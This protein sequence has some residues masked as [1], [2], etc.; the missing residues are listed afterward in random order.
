MIWGTDVLVSRRRLHDWSQPAADSCWLA[1]GRSCRQAP[2]ERANRR[3][4]PAQCLKSRQTNRRSARPPPGRHESC[5][6][7]AWR[8]GGSV[9]LKQRRDGRFRHIA[10][11]L[12]RRANRLHLTTR[13]TSDEL[14]PKPARAA[15]SPTRDRR[16]GRANGD[17]PSTRIP[18]R[19]G[20]ARRQRDCHSEP[21]DLR[22]CP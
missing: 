2:S 4:C 8:Q 13:I 14:A 16:H 22:Q 9:R 19:S 15:R 7:R 3:C 1:R 12:R 11:L 5:H 21:Q 17:E 10:W 20:K 18:C 6:R